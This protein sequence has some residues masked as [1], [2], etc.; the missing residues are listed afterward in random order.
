MG[1]KHGR[2]YEDIIKDFSEAILSVPDFY[3]FLNIT[4]EEWQTF[5]KTDQY[6]IAKTLADDVFYGLDQE[7]EIQVGSCTI[8]YIANEHIIKVAL[9]DSITIINLI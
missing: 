2:E 4:S 8:L 5:S 6:N 1:L 3:S 7:P 9:N